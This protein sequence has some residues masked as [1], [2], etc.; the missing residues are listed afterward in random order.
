VLVGS[1]FRG[2]ACACL[3]DG[4]EPGGSART[5]REYIPV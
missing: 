5:R 4:D 1:R 2:Q 3:L